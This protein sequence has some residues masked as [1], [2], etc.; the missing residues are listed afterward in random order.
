LLAGLIL[1]M[2]AAFIRKSLQKVVDNP[3]EIEEMLGVPVYAAIPHSKA[4]TG[5]LTRPDPGSAEQPALLAKTSPM[6][7]AVESLR[8][9]RT[10]L[11]Y[12]MPRLAGKVVLITGP[13]PGTG[14]SFVSANLAALLGVGGKQVL[15]IDGDLRNGSLHSIFGIGRQLGLSE[16]IVGTKRIENVIHRKVL[17]NVDFLSTGALLDDPSE[18]LMRPSTG[19][20]LKSL[21][22]KY[23]IVLI[24]SAPLLAVSDSILLGMHAS[25]IY[26][27]T[28]AGVTTPS[29]M[30]ES[31]KRLAQAGLSTNGLVF[32]G[33]P[34]RRKQY[35]YAYGRY[36]QV[37]YP[38]R[39]GAQTDVVQN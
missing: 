23:D 9:F 5:L 35:G 31:L 38:S 8:N 19:G 18:L 27:L 16:V 12:T 21:E 7:V 25:A 22:A 14:K 28:R 11:Q 2:V 30:A 36:W 10:V 37:Q 3:D 26:L 34:L 17:T 4:Q 6:D 13:T 32:N 29:D 39:P 1:G 15:L 33:V 24:D 20:L